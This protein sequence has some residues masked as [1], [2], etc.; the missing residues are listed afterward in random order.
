MLKTLFINNYALIDKLELNFNSG[1][2]V[3]TGETGAGKSIII[4]ALGLIL[5]NRADKSV[6][7]ENVNNKCIIEAVY[8]NPS[9]KII[10]LL[11]EYDFD[12]E[13]ELRIR[14]EIT[15]T[16]KSR[17]FIN[18]TPAS[19]VQL[20]AFASLLVDVNSQNQ[21][22][23]YKKSEFQIAMLDNLASTEVQL[24]DYVS[25]YKKCKMIQKELSELILRE[26]E[27]Q[28]QYDFIK[29]QFEE[30]EE[31]ALIE[32][33]ESLM[34][35]E[36]Q[37]LDNAELI[38]SALHNTT[39]SL[40]QKDENIVSSLEVLMS[41]LQSLNSFSE[42]YSKLYE[43]I[44]S[45]LIELQDIAVEY[46]QLNEE[47]EFDPNK[48]KQLQDRLDMILH[49]QQKHRLHTVEELLEYKNLLDTK[50]QEFA[51]MSQDI[52]KLES[53]YKEAKSIVESKAAVLSKKRLSAIPGIM[54]RINKGL[55]GLGMKDADFQISVNILDNVTVNGIDEIDFL[56]SSNKGHKAD[57]LAKVASG[58]EL[59]RVVLT[60]KSMLSF[61]NNLPTVI[62]DE[63]DTGVSGDIATKVGDVMSQMADNMQVI[64]ITHLPQ[65]A[66]KGDF[67][68]KVFKKELN[69]ITFSDIVLLDPQQ[70][71]SELA[72]MLSGDENNKSALAMASELMS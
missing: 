2:N 62:F 69:D 14:R 24:K 55:Q 17:A 4:G 42:R 11:T 33:E 1:L 48:F 5:G 37:I 52:I 39:Q 18:D 38:K 26:E 9:D 30:L 27:A 67:H 6:V 65:I 51:S 56:F 59:S 49:L 8:D 70:R 29:F 68:Y 36:L 32:G 35:S 10:S 66:S 16:G 50:L 23:I 41:E 21:T 13:A 20:K 47:T 63:I 28:K 25:N 31:A 72:M 19:L 54:R 45:S 57:S 43:R 53:K 3:I 40:S 15:S 22:Y 34:R 61:N 12:K 60:L 44:S 58:G 71:K 7:N 64:A 46:E